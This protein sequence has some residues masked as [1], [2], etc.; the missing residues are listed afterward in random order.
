MADF[1]GLLSE[2]G[3]DELRHQLRRRRLMGIV[4]AQAIGGAEGLIP[5]RLLQAC[6][7]GVVT[8]QAQCRCG[9]GEVEIK[10]RLPFFAGLMGHVAGFASHVERRVATA[11]VGNVQSDLVATEAEILFFSAGAGFEQL[12]LVIAGVRIVALHA[13]AHCRAVHR[14]FEIGCVLVGVAGEA[15]GRGRCGDQ[16]HPGYVLVDPDLVTAHAA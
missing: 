14:A 2:G 6:V 7:L 13:I 10:F 1:A 15:Q 5:M 3:M 12:E 9:F 16:L 8:I 11:F 4:A